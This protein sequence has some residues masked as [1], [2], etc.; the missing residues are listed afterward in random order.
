M[1]KYPWRDRLPAVKVPSRGACE[2]PDG[3]AV[4]DVGS[5]AWRHRLR[6]S[7]STGSVLRRYMAA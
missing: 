4:A 2:P 7:T 3:M 6:G 1:P 5:G